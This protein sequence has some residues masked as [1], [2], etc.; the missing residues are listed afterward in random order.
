MV[1]VPDVEPP[2]ICVETNED[3]GLAVVT[4]DRSCVPPCVVLYMYDLTL[5]QSFHWAGVPRA[6]TMTSAPQGMH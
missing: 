5:L 6:K 2:V 4:Q 1:F 3:G